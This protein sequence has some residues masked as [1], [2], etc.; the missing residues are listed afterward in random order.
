MSAW[1][2]LSDLLSPRIRKLDAELGLTPAGLWV[3]L[4]WLSMRAAVRAR[5]FFEVGN[6]GFRERA[7]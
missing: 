3:E 2:W 1:F 7:Q 4:G 6:L 5:I